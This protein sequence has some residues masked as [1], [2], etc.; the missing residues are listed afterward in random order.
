MLTESVTFTHH[1]V[2]RSLTSDMRTTLPELK[3]CLPNSQDTCLAPI[4]LEIIRIFTNNHR[5][6]SSTAVVFIN[7]TVQ[8]AVVL[9]K[10]NSINMYTH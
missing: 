9:F 7:V 1:R 2:G 5:R 3:V 10:K 4:I 6:I 8:N